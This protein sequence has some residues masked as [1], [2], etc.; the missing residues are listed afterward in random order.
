MSKKAKKEM[1]NRLYDILDRV[2]ANGSKDDLRWA[3]EI[4]LD[5]VDTS[6]LKDI[7]EALEER[8]G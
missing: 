3:V 4:I 5:E 2:T 8:Y 1:L 6:S 7:L